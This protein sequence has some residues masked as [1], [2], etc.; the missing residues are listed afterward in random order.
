MIVFDSMADDPFLTAFVGVAALSSLDAE[1]MSR[2]SSAWGLSTTTITTITIK[3]TATME[4][5]TPTLTID[6]MIWDSI[7]YYMFKIYNING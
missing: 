3:P 1:V 6:C 2:T 5:P 4:M 7:F